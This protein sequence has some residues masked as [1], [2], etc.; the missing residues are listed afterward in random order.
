MQEKVLKSA[1][2]DNYIIKQLENTT[3]IIEEL[4]N[5]KILSEKSKVVVF[6]QYTFTLSGRNTI[7]I[8]NGYSKHLV[9]KIAKYVFKQLEDGSNRKILSVTQIVSI[10]DK[11]VFKQLEDGSIIIGEI[12]N[13]Q[14]DNVKGALREFADSI[15]F[16]YDPT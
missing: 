14:C 1:V 15:G 5:T 13:R 2:F 3:I 16:E 10:F 11:Y 8:D 6:N 12:S 7:I 4:S 9:T